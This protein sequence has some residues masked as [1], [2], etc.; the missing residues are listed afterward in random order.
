MEF[1]LEVA[2]GLME[3]NGFLCDHSQLTS[4]TH[5]SGM[6]PDLDD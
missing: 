2:K 6:D 3:S 4:P 5:I 1:W